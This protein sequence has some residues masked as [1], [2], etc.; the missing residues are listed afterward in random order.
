M[1]I[2]LAVERLDVHQFGLSTCCCSCDMQF[3]HLPTVP[4]YCNAVARTEQRLPYL[5]KLPM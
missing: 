5:L 4:T 3:E 1:K 2:A